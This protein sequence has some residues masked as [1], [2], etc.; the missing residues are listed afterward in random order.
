MNLFSINCNTAPTNA[1][2][3]NLFG[4]A[5]MFSSESQMYEWIVSGSVTRIRSGSQ[6]C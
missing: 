4:D 3:Q 5:P 1:M 2:Q 6:T